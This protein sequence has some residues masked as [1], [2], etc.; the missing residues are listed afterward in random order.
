LVSNAT[1]HHFITAHN[2]CFVA[3]KAHL[4]LHHDMGNNVD[5]YRWMLE[6]GAVGGNLGSGQ[7]A[8]LSRKQIDYMYVDQQ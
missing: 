6:G 3:D 2:K 8:W 7:Q 4:F 1:Q 5:F